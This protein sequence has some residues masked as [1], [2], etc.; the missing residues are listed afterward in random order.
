MVQG[1][2]RAAGEEHVRSYPTPIPKKFSLPAIC[3][4]SKELI[5]FAIKNLLKGERC[6]GR[7]PAPYGGWPPPKKKL[8]TRKQYK[9]GEPKSWGE[10]LGCF[11]EPL[12]RGRLKTF[13]QKKVYRFRRSAKAASMVGKAKAKPASESRLGKAY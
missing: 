11:V 3:A 12:I 8:Y 6:F 4:L 7:G 1:I 10:V 9:T 5:P 2:L 13:P